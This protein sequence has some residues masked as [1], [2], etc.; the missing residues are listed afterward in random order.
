MEFG[1]P[2][3]PITGG[4][5]ADDGF[6]EGLAGGEFRMPRCG[7]CR[8]WRWPA[9]W[10]CGE[11]GGWVQEWVAVEP[12]GSVYTWTRSWMVFDRTTARGADVPYVVVLAEIPAANGARVLG[13]LAG[14]EEGLAIGAPVRG[15]VASPEGRSLGYPSVVWELVR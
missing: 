3:A 7:D 10:R 6:W 12:A 14:D 1:W 15:R 13:A 11:C 9:N 4:I 8:R 2:D 5:H